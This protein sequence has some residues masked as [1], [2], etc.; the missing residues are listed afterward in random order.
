LR[1]EGREYWKGVGYSKLYQT[2]RLEAQDC[3]RATQDA[4]LSDHAVDKIPFS[5]HCLGD[6]PVHFEAIMKTF[7]NPEYAALCTSVHLMDTPEVNKR[8][9]Q[10]KKTI[11]KN[12]LLV[13]HTF[14][15][16]AV[17]DHTGIAIGR[18]VLWK[19]KQTDRPLNV[20]YVV[21]KAEDR[22]LNSF[23]RPFVRGE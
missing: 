6:D 15:K 4:W 1:A 21:D 20:I 12:V 22:H 8:L 7:R 5:I 23:L 18:N 2:D 19:Y 16:G 10:L 14:N 9:P 3:E 17:L 13:L 11:P